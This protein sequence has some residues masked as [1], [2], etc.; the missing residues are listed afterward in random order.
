MARAAGARWAG[1]GMRVSTAMIGRLF[2]LDFTCCESATSR[3]VSH[4]VSSRTQQVRTGGMLDDQMSIMETRRMFAR[5]NEPRR[6]GC[7]RA[8]ARRSRRLR[9]GRMPRT[10]AGIPDR[11]LAAVTRAGRENIRHRAID[12]LVKFTYVQ[13][14]PIH[15]TRGAFRRRLDGGERERHLRAGGRR[16]LRPRAVLGQPRRPLER[17]P[18]EWNISGIGEIVGAFLRGEAG[19]DIA[20]SIP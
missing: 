2:R 6:L 8:P 4:L 10:R 15:S 13:S 7:L 9:A 11:D 5:A 3:H 20:E 12:F 19:E 16:N 18:V 1:A 14:I 17:I